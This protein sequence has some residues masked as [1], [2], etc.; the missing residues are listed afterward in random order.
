MDQWTDL[1]ANE[2]MIIKENNFRKA[3]KTRMLETQREKFINS[4][5]QNFDTMMKH[6]TAEDFTD[7]AAAAILTSHQA[8]AASNQAVMYQTMKPTADKINLQ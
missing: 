1:E 4:P 3:I 5:S 6:A 2:N 8:G 7:P